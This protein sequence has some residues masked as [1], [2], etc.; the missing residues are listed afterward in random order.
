MHV[1]TL[2]LAILKHLGQTRS[3]VRIRMRANYSVYGIGVVVRSNV[4]DQSGTRV[5]CASVNNYDRLLRG[6][7]SEIAK[8][9]GNRVSAFFSLSH[10][11]EIN[12]VGHDTSFSSRTRLTVC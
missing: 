10:W 11:E 8:T 5:L 2:D 9:H 1:Q 4:L 3:V 6:I 7:R 12:L